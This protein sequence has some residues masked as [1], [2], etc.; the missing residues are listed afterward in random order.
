MFESLKPDRGFVRSSVLL[1][2]GALALAGC[3]GH[4]VTV[5]EGAPTQRAHV[6][7]K[8]GPAVL[9]KGSRHEEIEQFGAETFADYT[10][11]S[12]IGPY[13]VK[14]AKVIVDCVATGPVAA[15][16]SAKGKWYHMEAPNTDAGYFA[17]AN[18][19][20]NGDTSGPLSSQPAVD[21]AVPECP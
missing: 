18:T 14:G 3:G 12:G 6:E 13:L 4:T 7:T 19:F 10:H 11:A 2:S 15:A 8:P 1:A 17:A 5:T 21:P 16:P 20:E 9:L